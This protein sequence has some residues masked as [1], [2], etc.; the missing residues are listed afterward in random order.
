MCL[1]LLPRPSLSFLYL[2]L[3]LFEGYKW[4][5]EPDWHNDFYAAE[6]QNEE[7]SD[8]GD[9]IEEQIFQGGNCYLCHG[10]PN[11]ATVISDFY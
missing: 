9:N 1:S 7:G 11:V 5:L 6:A 10:F 2:Y 8:G 4:F 3:S